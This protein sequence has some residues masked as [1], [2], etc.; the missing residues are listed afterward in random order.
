MSQIEDLCQAIIA[1]ETAKEAE[2]FFMDLCTP[3]ELQAMK[4]RW[5]ALVL[6]KAGKTYREI[7]EL[8][9]VTP[10]TVGRVARSLQ[11]G[12]GGYDLIFDRLKGGK[13]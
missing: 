3:A 12:E 8:I 11:L 5:K 2:K 4:D 1:L 6:L 13:K 9:G 10:T 7:Y